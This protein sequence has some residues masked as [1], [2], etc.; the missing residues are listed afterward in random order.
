MA[1]GGGAI[2]FILAGWGTRF[3]AGLFREN[4][5]PIVIDA[6][7]DGTVL[8]FASVLSVMTGVLF[9]LAPAFG[10]TRIAPTRALKTGSAGNGVSYRSIGRQALAAGQIALSLVLIFGAALLVRTLQNLQQRRRRI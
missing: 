6:Q 4:Q 2:G 5:N 9:G 7:P 3:I 8:L 1:V 10:A